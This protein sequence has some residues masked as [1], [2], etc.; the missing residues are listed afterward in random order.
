MRSVFHLA[1]SGTP[2][3]SGDR[4]EELVGYVTRVLDALVSVEE[5]DE[6]P[7]AALFAGGDC[8]GRAGV[9]SAPMIVKLRNSILARR[10]APGLDHLGDDFFR[11]PLAD[12]ALEVAELDQGHL[13]PGRRGPSRPAGFPELLVDHRVLRGSVS[14]PLVWLWLITITTATDDDRQEGGGAAQLDQRA[15]RRS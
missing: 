5:L 12:R 6:V 3:P 14:P 2:A 15:G 9:D 1:M 4:G 7:A 11:V 8:G 13:G 10:C